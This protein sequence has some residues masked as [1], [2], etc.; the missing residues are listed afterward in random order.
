ML[1]K[2]YFLSVKD[3]KITYVK[4]ETVEKLPLC[5]D[6][7]AN[8]QLALAQ[9][10]YMWIFIKQDNNVPTATKTDFI[11]N[12]VKEKF[13]EIYQ[14]VYPD[15][16]YTF[17]INTIDE[18]TAEIDFMGCNL[19]VVR[20]I[21]EN[22]ASDSYLAIHPDNW[23]IV[24]RYAQNIN[25]STNSQEHSELYQLL[26]QYCEAEYKICEWGITNMGFF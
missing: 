23:D 3:K 17:I 25:A 12:Q 9:F 16:I 1:G 20:T 5:N 22:P 7:N 18:L 2:I 8:Y 21:A 24:K 11:Y 26:Y 15:D 10:E 13:H 19:L 4:M 6:V 14:N